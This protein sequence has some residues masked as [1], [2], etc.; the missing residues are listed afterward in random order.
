MIKMFLSEVANVLCSEL[1]KKKSS[2]A[3]DIIIGSIIIDSRILVKDG[4]FIALSG[5]NFNGHDFCKDAV[6]L[7]CC[8][9]V[10]EKYQE[11]C[12]VPQVVVKDTRIALGL[13]SAYVK[14]KAN[15]KTVA[16]TGSSGKTTVKEMISSI[17]SKLGNVLATNGNFNNDIGVPLTLLRLNESHNFAVIELGANHLGEID[18]TS[19]LV[20]PDVAVINN[21]AEA[22]LEGFGS[23]D[24]VADAKS[25]IFNHL[26]SDGVAVYEQGS[27]YS[28]DWNKKLNDKQ[29]KTFSST[30]SLSTCY[31][32]DIV[33]KG[34]GCARFLLNT[35]IGKVTITL[36]I[37][38]IHN[39][40]NAVVAA[41]VAL[42][43][44]A[45]LEDIQIGLR[46]MSAVKGRL[47]LYQISDSLRIIDDTYNANVG[48]TKVSIDLLSTYQGLKVLVLGDMGELGDSAIEHH[49]KIG[50]YAHDSK[51][52]LIL[53]Y[54]KLSKFAIQSF[55]RLCLA[56]QGCMYS[57][58]NVSFVN[59]ESLVKYLIK[60]IRLEAGCISILVK[61]SRSMQMEDI[62]KGIMQ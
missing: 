30:S 41:T 36:D 26:A 50:E 59:K 18:Y 23:L 8:G 43:F 57:Y 16:I 34:N 54:G 49:E 7:G 61:G 3:Q 55:N 15:V 5:E 44:G 40:S 11:D 25:E 35:V 51:I 2:Q 31:A 12:D 60:K 13:I 22:H 32:S 28:L 53:T 21:I 17:L 27:A 24:G 33:L 9:L 38:G 45:S 58:G 52:D 1:V 47:N 14:K 29:I 4:L 46:E 37:I 62:V 39:I 42:E 6:A 19:N 20:N 48:S 10:V 56:E